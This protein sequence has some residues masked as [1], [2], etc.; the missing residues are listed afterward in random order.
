M[1]NK[2][3]QNTWLNQWKF[4][5]LKRRSQFHTGKDDGTKTILIEGCRHR[6]PK[7]NLIEYLR[8]LN[9]SLLMEVTQMQKMMVQT[10]LG[11]LVSNSIF[12]KYTPT[13]PNNGQINQDPVSQVFRDSVLIALVTTPNKYALPNGPVATICFQVHCTESRNTDKSQ[14]EMVRPKNK[15]VT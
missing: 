14:Q 8:F 6:I 4:A 12:A 2:R 1:Q 11:H 9:S 10:A 3:P 13:T 15:T 5:D 7:H